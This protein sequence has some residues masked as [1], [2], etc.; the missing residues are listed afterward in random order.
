MKLTDL[1]TDECRAPLKLDMSNV[2]TGSTA[3]E[4]P[5]EDGDPLDVTAMTLPS[6]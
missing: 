5:N 4:S 1:G 3:S 2:T 6:N